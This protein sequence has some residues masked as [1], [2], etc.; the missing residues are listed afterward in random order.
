MI[1]HLGN[2]K[3]ASLKDIIGI[4][5]LRDAGINSDN[6]AF[7]KINEEEGFLE[8]VSDA[9]A[10]CFVVS[11]KDGRAKIYLSPL[12]SEALIRRGNLN[13]LEEDT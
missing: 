7:L 13:T 4:F 12:T 11:E 10:K 5:R 8:K 6:M 9:P 2:E 3:A 1:L